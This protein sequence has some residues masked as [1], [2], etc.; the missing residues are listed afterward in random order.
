MEGKSLTE[1]IFQEFYVAR[2]CETIFFPSL[3]QSPT[4][5]CML[6]LLHKLHHVMWDFPQLVLH[7]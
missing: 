6:I 3:Q 2:L 1:V 4:V 7:A 5:S